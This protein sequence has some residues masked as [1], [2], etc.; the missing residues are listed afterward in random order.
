MKK[1][2]KQKSKHFYNVVKAIKEFIKKF[3]N[4]DKIKRIFHKK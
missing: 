3:E 1:Q 4:N 2:K